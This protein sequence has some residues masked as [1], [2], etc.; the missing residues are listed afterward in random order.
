MRKKTKRT[1]SQAKRNKK[2]DKTDQMELEI[3]NNNLIM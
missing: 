2:V 1:E 3:S